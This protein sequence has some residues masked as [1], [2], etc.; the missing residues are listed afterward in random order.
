MYKYEYPHP[1]VTTDIVIFTIRD[2]RLQLLLIKR[3]ETPYRG[4]W[5]LP[6][7]FLQMKETLDECAAREL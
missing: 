5:A 7:G 3:R 4:K 6:G 2:E 1:A